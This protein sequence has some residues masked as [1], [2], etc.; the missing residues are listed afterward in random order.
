MGMPKPEASK[1]NKDLGWWAT[2]YLLCLGGRVREKPRQEE[3]G[4]V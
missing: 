4:P 2:M 3:A 1:Y